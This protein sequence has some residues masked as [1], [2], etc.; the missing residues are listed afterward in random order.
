MSIRARRPRPITRATA[1]EVT[2]IVAVLVV[3]IVAFDLAGVV[4]ALETVRHRR[5]R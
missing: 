2:A 1:V 3:G 4:A 5:A